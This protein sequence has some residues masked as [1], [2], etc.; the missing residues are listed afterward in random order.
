MH[1]NR[2]IAALA[3]ACVAVASAA[4]AEPEHGLAMYG[5][6]ALPP[7][8]VSLPYANPDAPKGGRIV[9]G[10]GGGFDAFNPYILK[11]RSP[12]GLR[13]HVFESLMGR[14]WDEPFTLY[15]L[16]AESV[17][18]GPNREW[19]EFQ[20]RPEAKF[21]DGTPLTVDDVIW[22]FETLAEKGLPRYAN[23]W[24]KVESVEKVGARGLRFTFSEQ[25]NELPLIL[26]LRPVLNPR[27][28]E[29]RD[30][31]ESTLD[32]PTATGPYTVG[33]FEPGRFIE[34][35]RDPDYWGKDLPFNRGQHNLD[36]IRYEYYADGDVIFE[37]FRAGEVSTFRESNPAKWARDYDFPAVRDGRIVKSEI[38]HQRPSGMEG[39]VF[40]TRREPF[41][42]WRVREALIQAFNFDFVNRTLNDG[43]YKRITSYFSNSDLAM[44]PGAAEGKVAELL[45][46]FEDT[47]LPGALDGYGLPENTSGGRDRAAIRRASALLEEAGWTIRQGTLRNADGEAFTLT[48]SLDSSAR[49]IS[50]TPSEQEAVAN[51]WRDSLARLG[52]AAEIEL[53]DSAQFAERK[54]AYDFDVIINRW[55]LSLSPGNEQYLYWGSDG[56]E[57]PGTRN[58]MGM[59]SPA[60][61]AMIDA[62]LTADDHDGFVAAVRA[63]DRVL[64]AGRYVVPFW[65]ADR[66]LMA[67]KATLR[68]P[69][70]LPVYGDWIGFLPDV[71]WSEE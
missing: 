32:V 56:V 13:V 3:A 1:L 57:Q 58:Y 26:G 27:D 64:M 43:A 19:V 4:L 33:R 63:L 23:A 21:S 68:F 24:D 9:F 51:I 29:G 16:L 46:P 49:L 62:M 17:E 28:W 10:E 65:F 69:D 6:P 59:D 39:F 61:E 38:P 15:G 37:A 55:G 8:F 53:V 11:G 2:R 45:A 48:I 47:L 54:D 30:F 14:S 22:S 60:A 25:D 35:V 7:D 20:L 34:F 41:R 36:V 40:N 12:Y 50:L 5:E 42:D 71:W 66:T 44:Q 52:I 67:H 18:T 31:A 70:T